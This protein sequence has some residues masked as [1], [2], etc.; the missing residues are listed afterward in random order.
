ME[1]IGPVTK[2]MQNISRLKYIAQHFAT[3]RAGTIGALD[4]LTFWPAVEGQL[5]NNKTLNQRSMREGRFNH[6]IEAK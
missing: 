4:P 2:S 5:K 3:S 1:V 6:F